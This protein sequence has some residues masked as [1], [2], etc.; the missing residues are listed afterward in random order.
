[1][2]KITILIALIVIA[3]FGFSQALC[4]DAQ[5]LKKDMP[6]LYSGIY[7]RAVEEWGSDAAMILW[8][9][10]NQSEAY[11]DLGRDPDLITTVFESA[12]DEW[13]DPSYPGWA[14][15]D[16]GRA[17]WVMIRWEYDRQLDALYALIRD[18]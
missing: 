6:E 1:M 15:Y 16:Y 18:Y 9:I 3:Q 4:S 17:D 8:E 14:H 10:N 11:M 2:K 12:Y 7:D 5:I 13:Y